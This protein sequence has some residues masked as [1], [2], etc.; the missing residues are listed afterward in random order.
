MPFAELSNVRTYY[1]LAGDSSLPVLAFSHS[2]GVNHSMWDP[3]LAP[4]TP[5][6]RLLRYDIRGHGQ[7]SAPEGPYSVN[8]LGRDLVDLLDALN[9]QQANF[10]GLSMGGAI[11]QWLGLYAPNRITRLILSNTAAKFG[12]TETWNARIATVLQNGL[13]PIVQGT[14]ERWFTP[15]F[16]VTHSD[17]VQSTAAHLQSNSVSGYVGCCAAVRDTDF[18]ESVFGIKTPTLVITGTSDPVTP[19]VDGQF[20]AN[21][22]PKSNY[23]E[24]PAAHLSSVEVPDQFSRAL[25]AF[26]R[27]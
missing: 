16:R 19:P 11:G 7:S 9:I 23:V 18:R 6:F 22:I 1:E 3:Q 12:V 13:E 21:N 5:H 27:P 15:E 10:C 25:L 2:L 26:L 20:L 24:L 14:M 8:D 4:L 17:V